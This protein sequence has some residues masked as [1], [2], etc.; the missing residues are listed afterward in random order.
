MFIEVKTKL[1]Q[2]SDKS[3]TVAIAAPAS[4]SVGITGVNHGFGAQTHARL[5][6][7]YLKCN[8]GCVWIFQ[9]ASAD[10]EGMWD[11]HR[12]SLTPSGEEVFSIECNFVFLEQEDWTLHRTCTYRVWKEK[13]ITVL[14]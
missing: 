5:F 11:S 8:L 2:V 13:Q 12:A 9:D 6:C 14:Q 3:N 1:D 4:V 7:E 10:L